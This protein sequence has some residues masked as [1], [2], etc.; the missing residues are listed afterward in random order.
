L[1]KKQIIREKVGV[2]SIKAKMREEKVG[3]ASIKAKMREIACVGLDT[4]KEDQKMS[5]RRIEG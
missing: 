3:V 1:S 2:A 4:Y 5:I